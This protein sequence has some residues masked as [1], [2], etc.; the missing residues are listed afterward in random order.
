MSL[1][2]RG[3]AR[4]AIRSLRRNKARSAVTMLGVVIGVSAVTIA[5]GIGDGVKMQIDAQTRRLGSDLITIRPGRLLG[6]GSSRLSSTGPLAGAAIGGSLVTND[7]T[8]VQKAPGIA[9]AVP[10]SVVNAGM[11]TGDT[12]PSDAL[13]I[14]TEPQ[15]PGIL[16]QSLAYGTFF[17]DD[18]LSGDKVVLGARAADRLFSENVPLG[19]TLT[20]LGHQFVVVGILDAFQTTPLSL[21]ADFNDAVF[22]PY[23]S[24]RQITNDDSPLYEILARPADAQR[25]DTVVGG[26]RQAL[27]TSHGGQS[28]FT[29]LKQTQTLAVAGSILGMLTALIAGVAAIALLVGGVGIMNVM[30]VSVT[31]RMHEIGI[32]KAIGATSR[33]ILSQFVTEAAVLS[34]AGGLIGV[35][36]AALIEVA[37]GLLTSL[38]PVVAW[39]AAVVAFLVS[40]CIGVIFGSIPAAKAARKQPIEALRSD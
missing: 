14:G 9:K 38:K 29:V 18:E 35:I 25:T 11:V 28:D 8:V 33:Q 31:E 26:L 5:V 10:L 32:R 34:M 6:T 30:L 4:G 15:L 27:L 1:L 23:T 12:A 24:A 20:I 19:Q 37:V 40:V 17:G 36:L 2:A 16:R 22:I 3:D 7:I 13:V 39:Q 21:D